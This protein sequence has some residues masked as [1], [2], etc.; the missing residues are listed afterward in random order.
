MSVHWG[1]YLQLCAFWRFRLANSRQNSV[2]ATM[3]W[4]RALALA[5]GADKHKTLH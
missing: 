1:L 4:R 2:L 5:I 3:A